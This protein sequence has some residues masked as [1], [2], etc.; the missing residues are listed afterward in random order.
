MGLMGGFALALTGL[1]AEVIIS[2]DG[3]MAVTKA[4]MESP[5]IVLAVALANPLIYFG[6]SIG[7]TFPFNMPHRHSLV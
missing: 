5:A 7:L 3:H 4:L 1:T 2:F 6:M